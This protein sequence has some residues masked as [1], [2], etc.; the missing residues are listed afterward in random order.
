MPVLLINSKYLAFTTWRR[1]LITTLTQKYLIQIW[2][3][4]TSFWND[5]NFKNFFR[6]VN[7]VNFVSNLNSKNCVNSIKSVSSKNCKKFVKI[8]KPVNELKSVKNVRFSKLGKE[9]VFIEC[10][11]NNVKVNF[12]LDTG[13]Y[14]STLRKSDL[15]SMSNSELKPTS[16]RAKSYGN[17]PI[18]F[19]GECKLNLEFNGRTVSHKFLI[20][21]DNCTSLLGR[22]LCSKLDFDIKIPNCY[23]IYPAQDVLMDKYSNF[24]SDSFKSNVTE[25]VELPL[26]EGARAVY[27][28]SRPVP[29]KMRDLVLKELNN[30]RRM[31]LFPK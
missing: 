18:K 26:K 1:A 20:V 14:I 11:V 3:L 7:Y 24:M 31:A 15:N 21:E 8:G 10:K 6:S 12:E 30:L 9:P 22:D 27:C 2:K 29:F 17:N 5:L 28:K 4:F 19:L 25:K 23:R 13:S 16:K